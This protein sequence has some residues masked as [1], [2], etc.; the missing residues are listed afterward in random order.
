MKT[1]SKCLSEKPLSEFYAC[2]AYTDGYKGS[3]KKCCNLSNKEY[4]SKN[5][6]KVRI[7]RA[8]WKKANKTAVNK[9][10]REWRNRTGYM[11]NYLS[12]P[13]HKI[14]HN[15]RKRISRLIRGQV[16]IS[17]MLDNLGCSIE[18]LIKHL[19]FQFEP[20]MNWNNYGP[21]NS[22]KLTW[23]I[24]HIEPLCKFDLSNPEQ[25]KTVCHYSN[26]RPLLAQ[27]NSAKGG[28]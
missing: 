28:R 4:K 11:N 8:A 19:E 5:T 13:N 21:C 2:S 24:D 14:A 12:N 27:K 20:W 23:N 1:C 15:L 26:L 7:G 25:L 18:Y 17:S 10:Q 22:N 6:E 9:K 3:C 16:K